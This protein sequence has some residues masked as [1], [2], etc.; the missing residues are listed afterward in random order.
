MSQTKQ[1]EVTDRAHLLPTK[2]TLTALK[3]DVTL[4]SAILELCDNALDAWEYSSDR[5]DPITININVEENGRTELIIRDN[6]GGIPQEDAAMLFG[7]GQT[8]KRDI[9]GSIGTF[10]VG[11]KKS[12]VNLGVPFTISSRAESEEVGWTYRITED[13]FEDDQNWTVPVHT[14]EEI[15]QGETEIR[16]EDLNYEWTEETAEGLRERLG[17]AYNLFLSE[18]MQDLHDSDYDLNIL[19]DNEPVE[20][21]GIPNWAYS[22]FDGLYPRRYENIQL[23]SPEF[24]EPVY[25]HITVGLLTKKDNQRAGTDIYCQKRMVASCL[26][27]DIGGFGTGEDRLGNFNPRHQRLKVIVELETEGDGQMLPWDTQKS[28]IDKHN[29]LMRGTDEC[30]GVYNW[31][32]RTV[33]TYFDLDADQVLQA[34]LEP[35]DAEHPA[36][37]NN[38]HPKRLNYSDRTRVIT[39]HRPDPNLPD[40]TE[41]RQKAHCHA[42]LWISCE[43]SIE[44]SKVDA[45]RI[46]LDRDS[47]RNL[48]NLRSVDEAPPESIEEEPHQAAGRISTLAR[49]H[50]ENGI[51]CDSYLEDWEVARYESFMDGYDQQ[52]VTV[53]DDVPSDIPPSTRDLLDDNGDLVQTDG[54]GPAVYTKQSLEDSSKT[55]EQAEIFIVLG[56][57][58]GEERGAQIIDTS[59][60]ELCKSL[61]LESNASDEELW[62]EARR[63]LKKSIGI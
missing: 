21:E 3:A 62:E 43:E 19:V 50:Y 13:W 63:H 33:Q 5:T 56:A 7:L 27:D 22:P 51:Y 24:E 45:Y 29:P 48:Q 42:Q 38:G 36:A 35:Y 18:E 44:E 28:S 17:E 9:T 8:A 16:I 58:S 30:R 1:E 37:V 47:D 25:L 34:F 6:A 57:D 49:K 39:T 54:Q 55:T 60:K 59:R 46:Q 15:S 2:D 10:G 4:E 26:R 11:A 40:A 32:R 31:L 12:L 52:R 23:T 20:P 53:R 61:G 41:I 14:E